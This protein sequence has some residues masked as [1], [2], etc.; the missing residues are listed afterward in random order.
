MDFEI[1]MQLHVP[2]CDAKRR[3]SETVTG[4]RDRAQHKP[5]WQRVKLVLELKHVSSSSI[6]HGRQLC[7]LAF[8]L[9]ARMALST[10]VESLS[11]LG[12]SKGTLE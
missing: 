7:S 12:F 3:E 8:V 4:S 6:S 11:V 2:E 10:S 9:P 5:L 1:E